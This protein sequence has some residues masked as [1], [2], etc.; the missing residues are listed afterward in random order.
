MGR[1]DSDL[2]DCMMGHVLPYS[3][4]YDR[5]TEEDIKSSYRRA[6]NWVSLRPKV[7]VTKEDVQTEVLK[8]LAGKI[9]QQDMD[10]ISMNLGIPTPQIQNLIK[11]ITETK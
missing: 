11:L 1:V 10:K 6:E 7:G 5:W 4:A 9:Q 8:V 2:L 3:G